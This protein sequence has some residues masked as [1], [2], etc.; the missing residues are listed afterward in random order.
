MNRRAPVA[1]AV[2]ATEPSDEAQRLDP[3]ARSMVYAL[4]PT[5]TMLAWAARKPA[6]AAASR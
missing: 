5:R 4:E 3:A 1:R 6:G 2:E